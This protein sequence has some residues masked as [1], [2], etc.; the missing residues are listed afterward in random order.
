[1]SK[2]KL[3]IFLAVSLWL[4]PAALKGAVSG[5][6][7]AGQIRYTSAMGKRYVF[8]R[9]V[10]R[11]YDMRCY[12]WQDRVV[13]YN[14]KFKLT[15]FPQSKFAIINGIKIS[16]LFA[17]YS[18]GPNAFINDKDYL[19]TIEPI[20]RSGAL[21]RHRMGLIML[22]P[23]HGGTDNGCKGRILREKD[24]IL[25]ISLQLVETLRRR[26]FNVA[27]TRT[28][29]RFIEL[30]DRM[31]LCRRV[32]ADLFISIHGN[33]ALNP[34]INGIETFCL[35]PYGTASTNSG[36]VVESQE[37]GNR[38][39]ANNMALAFEIQQELIKRTKA[40]DRGIK[41][42]RFFVLK[43]A[44]CPAVLIETGFL[45]NGAEEFKLSMPWY[46]TQIVNG[47]TEGITSYS[48]MVSK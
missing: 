29:D 17:A 7:G 40:F 20:I 22:D 23:G 46:Q 38:F 3:L 32:N 15:F 33:S 4:L 10:A 19:L 37:S 6:D 18:S 25:K 5:N 13:L 8:L 31:E 30:S 12:A 16:L 35:A 41:R 39:D 48:R 9:D 11:N 45:S 26:G 44:P 43:N 42:A 34:A 47:I 24:L 27:M 1:M 14:D 28:S 2:L 36:R 21:K